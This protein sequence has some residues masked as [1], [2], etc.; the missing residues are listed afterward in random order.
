MSCQRNNVEHRVHVSE[1]ETIGQEVY[2]LHKEATSNPAQQVTLKAQSGKFVRFLP[3]T[4]AQC[5]V[6][7]L[8][9]Y[10]DS[11]GDHDLANVILEESILIAYGG[12]S[13]KVIG[14]TILRVYRCQRSC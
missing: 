5:D 14:E 7:P 9:I 8:Q 2:V 11:S 1:L 12:S 6:L 3:D 10:K 4:R 13:V